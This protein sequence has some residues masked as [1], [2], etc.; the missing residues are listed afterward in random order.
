MISSANLPFLVFVKSKE[1]DTPSLIQ[2]DH[3]LLSISTMIEAL[4]VMSSAF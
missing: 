1:Y 3:H 2:R 4:I